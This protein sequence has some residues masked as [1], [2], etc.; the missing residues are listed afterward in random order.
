MGVR[1]NVCDSSLAYRDKCTTYRKSSTS[2]SKSIIIILSL[3]RVRKFCSDI[4]GGTG[5]KM[6][7]FLK[8]NILKCYFY[9]YNFQKRGKSGM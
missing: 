3:Y 9:V 8:Q 2:F 1:G 6:F 5:G 7:S 4:H